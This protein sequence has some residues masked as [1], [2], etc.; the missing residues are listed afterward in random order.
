MTSH[1]QYITHKLGIALSALAVV[2]WCMLASAQTAYAQVMLRD[3][4]TEWFLRKISDPIFVAAKLDPKS[5]NMYILGANE[6]NAFVAGGQNIFIL[7]GLILESKDVNNLIG[8]IAHETGHI[9][10]G[11]N[12]RR[13]EMGQGSTAIAILSMIAG[14]AAIAAGAGDAGAGIMMG[15]QTMAQRTMLKYNRTQE[16]TTDQAG[17]KFLEA[18]ETSGRGLVEFFD[19]LRDQEFLNHVSQDPYVRTHPL[20]SERVARLTTLMQESPY[21]DKPVNPEYEYWFKRV[22]AK[23][24]GYMQPTR[25]TLLNYPVNDKSV[26]A[27]YARVY[28]YNKGLQWDKAIEEAKSL[29][30]DFPDDPYFQE[31]T[32]QILLENGRVDE[33]LPYFRRSAELLPNHPLILMSLGHALVALEDRKH[34]KEARDVLENVVH[35]DPENSFAWRQLSVVYARDKDE[36]LTNMATAEYFALTGNLPKPCTMPRLRSISSTPEA[37]HGFALKMFCLP[38]SSNLKR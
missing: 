37:P 16:A 9:S 34:D 14:A 24:M 29:V 11:H 36:G 35:H 5:V 13:S 10:G 17:A 30:H 31:I 26:E 15:G 8:V 23:L 2:V 27:R 6:L 7:S 12:V 18:T 33:S 1:I 28:A 38:H 19:R 3:A 22:K 20:S 21:W 25:V 32:G 4:E